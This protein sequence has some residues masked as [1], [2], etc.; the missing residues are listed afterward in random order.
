MVKK[1]FK[2]EMLYYVKRLFLFEIILMSVALFTRLIYLF[3]S[4]NSIYLILAG[5]VT[6]VL[7]V[8]N[9][10]FVIMTTIAIIT[11][12]YKNLYSTEGYFTFTLPVTE[13]QHLLVKLVCAFIFEAVAISSCFLSVAVATA[14]ELGVEL[15]KAAVYIFNL[16]LKE[17]NINAGVYIVEVLTNAITSGIFGILLFYTC[18]SLGQ[19]SKRA[20]ILVAFG[21]YMIYCG[22]IEALVTIM[23]MLSVFSSNGGIFGFIFENPVPATHISLI[24]GTVINI[25]AS[26]GMFFINRSIM[27]KKLNLE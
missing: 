14:G 2:Y 17:I 3:P 21:Y 10:L 1:L 15:F 4:T 27:S 9:L 8:A 26:I 18:I 6:F 19:L 7:Y 11:R 25:G 20:K 24:G 13:T 16:L 23:F 22:I 12:F 5:S